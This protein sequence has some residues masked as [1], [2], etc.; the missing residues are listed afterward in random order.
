MPWLTD[1]CVV[2]V[3]VHIAFTVLGPLGSPGQARVAW[4]GAGAKAVVGSES[5]RY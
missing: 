2:E 3:D 5:P 4:W 1:S